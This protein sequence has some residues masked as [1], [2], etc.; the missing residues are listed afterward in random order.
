LPATTNVVR[1]ALRVDIGHLAPSR[2]DPSIVSADAAGPATRPGGRPRGRVRAVRAAAGALLLGSVLI[3]CGGDGRTPLV[4]YS[5]HGRD[6][7]E[8]MET[9]FERAQ[10]AI[11]LRYL[12]MGSQEVYDR[13]R[14]ERANPQADVWYG[15]PDAIFARA[16]EDGLLAPYRPSWAEA[17]PQSSRGRDDLYFGTFRTL[18][19]LVWNSKRVPPEAAPRDWDDLL[20][21]RFRDRLLIRDPMASG[22]MRTFIAYRLARSVTE[23]GDV[24]AG[25]AW[26]ARLDAQTK[27]YAANPA[28]LFEML[29]RGE[30]D[31]TVWELTDVLL[32]QRD[33]DPIDWALPRSGTPVIDDAIALVAGAPHSAAA[34]AFLEYAGS[35]AAARLTAERVF[36]IPARSDLPPATLPEWAQRVLAELVPADYDQQL[37]RERGP[38]WMARWDR[39]IRGRGATA[40]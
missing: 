12:D 2:S 36:R 21:E 10:P 23:T 8:L 20:D 35:A 11:D 40:P 39:E 14:S 29:A 17:V 7:L 37:A 15:G 33:G 30:G 1:R 34:V 22:V 26:L 38:E 25:F 18:P 4:V 27:Q 19:A 24:D 28:L 13:I 9:E 31:V 5:P 16:A 6:L 32:H 3:G